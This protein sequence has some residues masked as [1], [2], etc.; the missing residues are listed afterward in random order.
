MCRLR[1]LAPGPRLKRVSS[2]M[3]TALLALTTITAAAAAQPSPVVVPR[4]GMSITRSVTIQRG[5]YRF[6]STST[7]SAVITIRGDDVTVNLT[8]VVLS[9]AKDDDDPDK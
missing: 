4:N 3:R 1:M 7:D 2:R 8:N 9:G 6:S 5:T